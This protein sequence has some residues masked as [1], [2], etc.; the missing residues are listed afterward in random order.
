MFLLHS[1][2]NLLRKYVFLNR[3]PPKFNGQ[4]LWNMD[5]HG[6]LEDD[7]ASFFWLL[8]WLLICF[9]S[10]QGPCPWSFYARISSVV[11]NWLT[12][13]IGGNWSGHG[14]NEIIKREID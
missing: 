10:S 13:K 12:K 8:S 1:L 9:F 2:C 3:P 6:W 14:Q 7:P 11:G 5:E 4:F